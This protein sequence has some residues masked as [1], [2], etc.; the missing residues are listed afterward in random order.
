MLQAL[1]AVAITGSPPRERVV[2]P[3]LTGW[4]VLPETRRSLLQTRLAETRPAAELAQEPPTAEKPPAVQQMGSTLKKRKSMMNKHK[5]KKRRK[6]DA[7][8]KR[9]MAKK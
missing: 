8:K 2:V 1:D 5:L 7:M 3:D 9:V 4:F 6:R